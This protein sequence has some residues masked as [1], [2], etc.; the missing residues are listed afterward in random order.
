MNKPN[1][2]DKTI[3][4]SDFTP[5]ELGGHICKI[6]KV[7]E[8]KSSTNKEMVLIYL[9]IAEGDQTG[10]FE[11]KYKSDNRDRKK[12]GCIVY[13][14][15]HDKDGNTNRG[16]KTFIDAV[17]RSNTKFNQEKIWDEKF[18]AY[19]KNMIVGGIFGREQYENSNGE[20][21]WATKC[22]HFRDVDT[23]RSGVDV[24]KDKYLKNEPI[25]T[26]SENGSFEEVTDAS[27]LPF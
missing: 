4:Y 9:D 21:K 2:W 13:Q 15:V 24:P 10:Y 11:E 1:A 3:G 25:Y 12:W 6:C 19:F 8:S 26:P 20:L 23:I 5:L 16:F 27:D 18:A 14:L 22:M 7:E 17:D